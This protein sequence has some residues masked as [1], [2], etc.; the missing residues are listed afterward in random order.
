MTHSRRQ[1]TGDRIPV[2]DIKKKKKKKKKIKLFT[3]K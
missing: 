2:D 1:G 3:M